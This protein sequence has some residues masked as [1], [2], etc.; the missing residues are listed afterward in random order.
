M[1]HK[2]KYFVIILIFFACPSPGYY[3]EC[4]KK[5]NRSV[6]LSYLI[7]EKI[8]SE[9]GNSLQQAPEVLLLFT[10]LK[11]ENIKVCKEAAR[12]GKPY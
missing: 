11:E 7:A 1:F 8:L 9:Q 5:A 10:V 4:E 2:Y 6:I 3:L 12:E